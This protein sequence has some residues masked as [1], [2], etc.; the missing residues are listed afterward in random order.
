MVGCTVPKYDSESR[1]PAERKTRVLGLM[2]FRARV[3]GKFKAWV[4]AKDGGS[5][6][7]EAQAPARKKEERKKAKRRIPSTAVSQG[8]TMSLLRKLSHPLRLRV[9]AAL[10][11]AP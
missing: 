4:Q 9:L 1:Q 10:N 11:P 7:Q 6:P 2:G 8:K 3:Q 5:N